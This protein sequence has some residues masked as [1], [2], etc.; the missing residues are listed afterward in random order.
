LTT[1]NQQLRIA[2]ARTTALKA[3]TTIKTKL[4]QQQQ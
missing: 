3:K 1:E 4:T 2:A